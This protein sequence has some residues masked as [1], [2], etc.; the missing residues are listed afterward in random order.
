MTSG[1]VAVEFLVAG[2]SRRIVKDLQDPQARIGLDL[3]HAIVVVWIGREYAPLRLH[4]PPRDPV[5]HPIHAGQ[6]RQVRMP[7]L[8]R[9]IVACK[10]RHGRIDANR[11][12]QRRGLRQRLQYGSTRPSGRLPLGI[13]KLDAI[14][15]KWQ[16]A[17][18]HNLQASPLDN[19]VTRHNWLVLC[20]QDSPL[21]GRSRSFGTHAYGNRFT[22][23]IDI[24]GMV[25]QRRRDTANHL[26]QC[27]FRIASRNST[28]QNRTPQNREQNQAG[29]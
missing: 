22:C 12:I 7:R 17:G 18:R 25:G 13:C 23:Q 21:R 1:V 8:L 27:R 24:A 20:I 15:A 28:P 3:R 11:R 16:C 19:Q 6:T 4:L 9:R 14:P 2:P 29:T 5:T 26:R 10:P